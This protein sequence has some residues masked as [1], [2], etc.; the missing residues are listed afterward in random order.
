MD[1]IYDISLTWYDYYVQIFCFYRVVL[2]LNVIKKCSL[3]IGC[4]F[5]QKAGP[6]AGSNV[7]SSS[8]CF[9]KSYIS[10][11]L[12]ILAELLDCA[13]T[14]EIVSIQIGIIHL[15]DIVYYSDRI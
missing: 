10:L 7:E 8:P 11:N 3:S 14:L 4:V 5:Y 12:R 1:D 6:P 13:Y 2:I 9:L 15:T